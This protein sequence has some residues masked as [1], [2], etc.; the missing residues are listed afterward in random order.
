MGG[1]EDYER[2]SLWA[3]I[4]DPASG[5]RSARERLRLER[6]DG[7][8][9]EAPA[10]LRQGDGGQPSPDTGAKAGV[11]RREA[12]APSDSE[13]GWGPASIERSGSLAG[14]KK[15]SYHEVRELAG[16]PAR[17][18]ALE[19]EQARLQAEAGSPDFYKASADRIREVL[20]RLDAIGPELDATMARWM[21]LEERR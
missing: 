7:L 10:R 1:Y 18:E 19:M 8:P 5:I 20:K 9:A 12:A 21:E 16:L 6:G 3:G 11:N 4:R 14:Y 2:Q 17:I 13:P 15:L